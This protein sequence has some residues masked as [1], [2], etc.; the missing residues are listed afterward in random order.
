MTP[1]KESFNPWGNHSPEIENHC[2]SFTS[3]PSPMGRSMY[4][5]PNCLWKHH[6]HAQREGEM[7]FTSTLSTLKSVALTIKI[8]SYTAPLNPSSE[9]HKPKSYPVSFTHLISL[10]I[11]P[12]TDCNH[13]DLLWTTPQHPNR[14]SC[15]QGTSHRKVRKLQ[16]FNITLFLVF[17][18]FI[19]PLTSAFCV[20]EV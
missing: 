11:A 14:F 8:N 15:F 13:N 4:S 20:P 7:W 9:P 17:P 16:A 5:G 3:F 2:S 10:S 6:R 1:V 18:V 19:S 12:I